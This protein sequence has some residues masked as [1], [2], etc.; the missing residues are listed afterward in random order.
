MLLG[1]CLQLNLHRSHL[2]VTDQELVQLGLR[3]F[4]GMAD[5]IAILS[6]GVI[7]I[8]LEL[9]QEFDSLPIWK[10]AS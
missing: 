2:R 1:L 4:P 7:V 10:S 5:A 8:P 9:V 6:L 3:S